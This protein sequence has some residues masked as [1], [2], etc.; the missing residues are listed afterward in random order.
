MLETSC[1]YDNYISILLYLDNFFSIFFT[2]AEDSK[3][4]EVGAWVSQR[5]RMVATLVF[6]WG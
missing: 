5:K 1:G 4:F 6:Y 2:V 3:H